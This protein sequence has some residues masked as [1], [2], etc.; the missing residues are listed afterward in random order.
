MSVFV[1]CLIVQSTAVPQTVYETH[2]YHPPAAV[3]SGFLSSEV[4]DFSGLKS[5]A[6]KVTSE[7]K[8]HIHVD[9][10]SLKSYILSI[11]T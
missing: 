4:F 1:L 5:C 10:D 8:L 2:R 9:N 3:L 7:G 11:M 6:D